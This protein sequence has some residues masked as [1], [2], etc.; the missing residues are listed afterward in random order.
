[1]YLLVPCQDK[2]FKLNDGRKAPPQG[3][4][5]YGETEGN[6]GNDKGET[7]WQAARQIVS[8]CHKILKPG[9]HAIWVVKAFVRKGKIVDFPGDW[10]RLC[11]DQGFR[12]V[13]EHHAML[14]KETRHE[15]LF[16]PIVEKKERKSFFRR[17]AESKGSPPIDYE[18]VL[19]MRAV[20]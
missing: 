13:H 7:F 2:K 11:E 3:Q 17:L 4:D 6:I 18:V 16:E 20:K 5:G 14:V 15:G 1:M 10:R 8:E 19:C 12:T 9:G